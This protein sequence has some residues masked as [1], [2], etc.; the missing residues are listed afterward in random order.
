MSDYSLESFEK[1]WKSVMDSLNDIAI[2]DPN[3]ALQIVDKALPEIL[4]KQ[5][6]V[7]TQ[8]LEWYLAMLELMKK[9]IE[10]TGMVNTDPN[11][12]FKLVAPSS[13]DG[14]ETSFAKK[15]N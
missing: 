9:D 12:Y 14:F 8:Q 1:I 10:L 2:N 5:P 7:T 6:N 15:L 11:H 3:K 13:K 4:K